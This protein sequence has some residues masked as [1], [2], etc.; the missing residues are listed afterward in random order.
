MR[1]AI[2]PDQY[3]NEEALMVD[4]NNNSNKISYSLYLDKMVTMTPAEK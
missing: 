2:T 1:R 3:L 4:I